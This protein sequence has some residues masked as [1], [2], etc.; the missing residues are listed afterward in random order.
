MPLNSH[1]IALRG[2]FKVP[3]WHRRPATLAPP[4]F[5]LIWKQLRAAAPCNPRNNARLA[6]C[7]CVL[8]SLSSR[9]LPLLGTFMER[10]GRTPHT[11]SDHFRSHHLQHGM[12]RRLSI[13]QGKDKGCRKK[14][15]LQFASVDVNS[16]SVL[17]SFL[18]GLRSAPG[19]GPYIARRPSY[20]SP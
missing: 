12:A 4:S 11:T 7:P 8:V 14:P 2:R 5:A 10:R 19:S 9:L 13:R 1:K 15:C 18:L 6:S 17:P 16:S 3:P 20:E